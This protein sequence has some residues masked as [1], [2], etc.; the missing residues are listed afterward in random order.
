MINGDSPCDDKTITPLAPGTDGGLLTGSYQRQP[1]KPFDGAG[2]AVSERLTKPQ[3]W[4]A[5][6]FALATNER[7]PQTGATVAA[8]RIDVSAG[9]LSGDLSAFAAAWNGQ[10]F[11]QGSPKP[12]GDRP[13]T[14]S[15]PVGYHDPDTGAYTLEWSSQIV[16]GPFNNFTGMW[17]L[18]GTFEPR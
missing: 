11:N 5:V 10:H 15:G 1:S 6:T 3:R 2:N 17:H 8:P 9:K 4:F 12:G 7:D 14:T 13:G 16:G 18:E